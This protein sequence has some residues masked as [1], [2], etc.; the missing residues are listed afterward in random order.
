MMIRLSAVDAILTAQ[1]SY[2][3]EVA[4]SKPAA[5]CFLLLVSSFQFSLFNVGTLV[6]TNTSYPDGEPVLQ[7]LLRG[8]KQF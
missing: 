2:Y 4:G 3:Y 8:D 7:K 5:N 1:L 6:K